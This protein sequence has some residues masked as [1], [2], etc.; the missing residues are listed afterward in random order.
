M[1]KSKL[2]VNTNDYDFASILNELDCFQ[3][4]YEYCKSFENISAAEWGRLKLED[5]DIHIILGTLS[6]NYCTWCRG[7]L[8]LHKVY[9]DKPEIINPRRGFCLKCRNCHSQGPLFHVAYD[10][11]IDYTFEKYLNNL[12]LGHYQQRIKWDDDEMFKNKK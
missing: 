10:L 11:S 7:E 8:I 5:I 12:L 1:S 4:V 9:E 2:Y 6:S 3:P